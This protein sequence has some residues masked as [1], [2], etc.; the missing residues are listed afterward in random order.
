MKNNIKHKGEFKIPL[1]GEKMKFEEKVQLSDSNIRGIVTLKKDG[2]TIFT[3]ENTIVGDGRRYIQDRFLK[4]FLPDEKGNKLTGKTLELSEYSMKGIYLGTGI[5]MSSEKFS[6]SDFKKVGD[7]SY[8]KKIEDITV[9][10][11]D[12]ERKITFV[13]SFEGDETKPATATELAI[14]LENQEKTDEKI[15]SRIGFD[16]VPVGAE[17][18][19]ELEYSIYF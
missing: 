12:N 16:P 5:E 2:K 11:V 6:L 14:F 15:F 10:F 1:K 3:K 19:F 7:V 17:S 8:F 13:C 18:S 4:G 9:L